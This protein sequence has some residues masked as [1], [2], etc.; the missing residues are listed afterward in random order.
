MDPADGRISLSLKSL[1]FIDA[2]TM[3]FID[4]RQGQTVELYRILEQGMGADGDLSLARR[5]GGQSLASLSLS[6]TTG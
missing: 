5:Q 2:E 1:T 4:D 3:L 6:V